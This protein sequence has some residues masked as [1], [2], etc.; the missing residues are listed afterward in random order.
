MSIQGWALGPSGPP[1]SI[2]IGVKPP[3]LWQVP[4]NMQRPDIAAK[5][6]EFPDATESGFHTQV[7]L[8]P[9]PRQFELP[10]MARFANGSTVNLAT[11]RGRR[12]ALGGEP[13]SSLLRPLM[14]TTLGR[15]GS[16]RTVQL[17]SQHPA[18]VGYR[19]GQYEP[20]IASYWVSVL[21]GLTEPVSYYQA[22]DGD[23][24]A[25]GWWLGTGRM[26]SLPH[27]FLD[28]EIEEWHTGESIER[29]ARFYRL[30]IDEFYRSV[31]RIQQQSA[32]T[33][34]VEKTAA[35]LVPEVLWDLY[36]DAREIVL[37]RD[38]RDMVSSMLAFNAKRNLAAFGRAASGSDVEFIRKLRGDVVQL[39]A[40][41][42]ERSDRA[43]LL[44]YEDL[45]LN[46]D[47][48]L[49]A[50]LDYLGL[51][52]SEADV[53]RLLNEASAMAEPPEQHRTSA[54]IEDSIGRWQRDLDGAVRSA[55][56]EA[57]ADLLPV[58]GYT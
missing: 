2:Q 36:P 16:T 35:G 3:A 26:R 32:P 14:I 13:D 22:L 57:F 29:L 9:L 50:L 30:Q 56:E 44:R 33:F 47:K 42:Q 54:S 38:L 6:R 28:S 23:I 58:L 8:I 45:I 46:P 24:A 20:R 27:R 41:W 48:T 52:S 15:T 12:G 34:F 7:S 55:C 31:A 4:M 43:Y 18:I 25:K 51:G 53:Q 40:N 39:I 49:G 11:I 37:V 5:M 21:A 17:L 1:T 10:V 19:P